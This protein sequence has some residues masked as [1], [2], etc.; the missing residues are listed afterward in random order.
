MDELVCL[1][2]LKGAPERGNG[3]YG[4]SL[5]ASVGVDAS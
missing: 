4:E 1:D 2:S 5:S 3:L